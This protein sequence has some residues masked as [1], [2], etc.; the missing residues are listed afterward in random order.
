MK[1]VVSAWASK[2]TKESV[3]GGE[4]IPGDENSKTEGTDRK[5]GHPFQE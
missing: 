4:H 3:P 5:T 2:E 1:D